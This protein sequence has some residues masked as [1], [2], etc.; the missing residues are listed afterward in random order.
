VE[1][2]MM[3]DSGWYMVNPHMGSKR[4]LEK[5]HQMPDRFE[6]KNKRLLTEKIAADMG[7]LRLTDPPYQDTTSSFLQRG[8]NNNNNNNSYNGM[9]NSLFQFNPPN[10]SPIIYSSK[11]ME[12][13][14]IAIGEP[15][16]VTSPP[17]SLCSVEGDE[18]VD[19]IPKFRLL[20]PKMQTPSLDI[21]LLHNIPSRALIL[22]TPPKEVIQRSITESRHNSQKKVSDDENTNTHTNINM[23]INMN[24]DMNTNSTLPPPCEPP[25][26]MIL[27]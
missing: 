7:V 18:E 16:F 14:I 15:A 25:D 10:Q 2:S 17:P 3:M 11:A 8:D 27:D 22:Y 21:P 26:L 24:M 9:G 20:I 19:P 4:K 12:G 5:E 1:T 13:A 23:N 6:P